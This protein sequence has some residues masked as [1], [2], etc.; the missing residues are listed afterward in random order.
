ME[1]TM[2]SFDEILKAVIVAG[3][4][5]GFMESGDDVSATSEVKV[6]FFGYDQKF[7]EED[8]DDD[9]EVDDH[10]NEIYDVY[11][12]VDALKPDFDYANV[13]DE[14]WGPQKTV[15]GMVNIRCVYEIDKDYLHVNLLEEYIEMTSKVTEAKI[16]KVLKSAF[17]SISD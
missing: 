1:S 13:I 5:E 2:A 16:N 4:D 7:N 9:E 17:K 15:P 10:N 12:H 11:I 8:E 14:Y 3:R 6:Y